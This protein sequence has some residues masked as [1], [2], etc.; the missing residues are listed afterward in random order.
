MSNEFSRVLQFQ[1]TPKMA[2]ELKRLVA[3]A[4]AINQVDPELEIPGRLRA[5]LDAAVQ[6]FP[7]IKEDISKV[8]P[9]ILDHVLTCPSCAYTTNVMG[10][11]TKHRKAYHSRSA[12]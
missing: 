12:K 2:A 6:H 3:V 9:K 10:D 5:E 8:A 7:Q 11:L 4:H 1:V